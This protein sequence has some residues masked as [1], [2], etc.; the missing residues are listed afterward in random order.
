MRIL[1]II[2]IGAILLFFIAFYG[3][4]THEK[5]IKSVVCTI[6]MAT[7][8]IFFFLSIGFRQGILPP[9]GAEFAYVEQIADPLPQALMITAIVIGV[10]MTT[11]NIT[12]LTSLFRKYKTTDWDV[13]KQ[14]SLE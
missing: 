8:V 5:M 9:I 13:A 11:I 12:M 10:A 4:I 3:L 7:A 1:D 2:E 6:I 14:K